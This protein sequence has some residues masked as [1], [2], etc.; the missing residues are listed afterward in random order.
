MGARKTEILYQCNLSFTQLNSYLTFLIDKD[1]LEEKTMSNY[2][3]SRDKFYRT[4]EKGY[5]LLEDINKVLY[6]F[7]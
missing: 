3:N 7:K 1:I 6:Y 4:T 5:T 2:E